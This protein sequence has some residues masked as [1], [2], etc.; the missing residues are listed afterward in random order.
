MRVRKRFLVITILIIIAVFPLSPYNNTTLELICE[1]ADF[2]A[3]DKTL[4]LDIAYAESSFNPFARGKLEERGL[5]QITPHTWEW[6]CEKIYG[7]KISFGLAFNPQI[8]IAMAMWYLQYLQESLGSRYSPAAL[9]CAFNMGPNKFK[10]KNFKI[11]RAHKN[12]IY[13]AYFKS[14]NIENEV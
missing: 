12:R 10:E 9:I 13:N 11:P 2:F 3:I 6:L 14:T 1:Y 4:A 7:E 5:Y 8:N